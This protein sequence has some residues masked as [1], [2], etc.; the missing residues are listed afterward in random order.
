MKDDQIGHYFTLEL[1]ED[2]EN[3]D[4]QEHIGRLADFWGTLLLDVDL[5]YSD[6]FGPHFSISDLRQKDFKRWIELFSETA[7]EI[8]T[9]EVSRIFKNK[10]VEFSTNFIER[11]GKDKNLDE[12]KSAI[13][14]E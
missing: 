3:E 8:Y 14:W 9:T 12:L 4:W 13:N 2:I 6:P 1:G 7:D 5:Y 11:L 10:G